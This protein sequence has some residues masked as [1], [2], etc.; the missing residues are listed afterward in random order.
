MAI[1]G[2]VQVEAPRNARTS[3]SGAS[4]NEYSSVEE[5]SGSC[6]RG[7]RIQTERQ[8]VQLS[9]ILTSTPKGPLGCDPP[10]EACGRRQE[11]LCWPEMHIDSSTKS[12]NV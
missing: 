1:T 8:G 6:G 11:D 7:A 5:S 4:R 9:K 12:K 3:I 2:R 10:E